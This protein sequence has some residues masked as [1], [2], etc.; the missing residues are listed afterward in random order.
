MKE[1][2]MSCSYTS[3]TFIIKNTYNRN[4]R[5]RITPLNTK[6]KV[7]SVHRVGRKKK[8]KLAE[9]AELNAL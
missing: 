9:N 6:G 3:L 5:H 2:S 1:P 7:E 4:N 8:K